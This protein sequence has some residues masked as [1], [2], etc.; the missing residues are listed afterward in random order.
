MRSSN[1]SIDE[2]HTFH[3]LAITT[4]IIE[5]ESVAIAVTISVS[6]T[7]ISTDRHLQVTASHGH[8]E[9]SIGSMQN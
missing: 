5:T 9:T 4:T 7:A 3:Y 8:L 1:Y 2:I 6:V